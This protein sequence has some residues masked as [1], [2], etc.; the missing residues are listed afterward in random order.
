MGARLGAL[1]LL[2]GLLARP[3]SL[4]AQTLNIDDLVKQAAQCE[5]HHD[6]LEACRLYD[7]VLRR[8]RRRDDGR[9]RQA[10]QRC[11]RRYHIVHRHQDQMYRTALEHL[12]PSQALDM[13][14]HVLDTIARVY[15]D[16]VKSSPA[17]LFAQGLEELRLAFAEPVFTREYF[18]G[19]SQEKLDVFQKK[20]SAWRQRKIAHRSEARDQ[21]GAVGRTAQQMGFG[22]RPILLTVITLEFL[23]GAC[24][25]LDEYTFFLS[26]GHYREVQ[27]ALRGRLVSI[28]VDLEVN[29]AHLEIRRIYS[30][31]PAE[32]AGLMPHDRIL[33][34]DGKSTDD[35]TAERAAELLRGRSG[36][37]VKL[38]VAPSGGMDSEATLV[39]VKRGPVVVPSVEYGMLK[40]KDSL[41]IDLGEGMVGVFP[42]GKM[43]INY[44]QEST[45]QEV[46]DALTTLQM[47]GMKVLILDLRGNPG[48]LFKSAV[49]IAELF[50]PEGIIVIS[51]THLHFKDRKLSGTIRAEQ[52]DAWL[53]P[54][55]VLIDGETASAAE[56]LAG[57]LKDNGR[58]KLI[59]RTTFGK[60][61]IQ[62]IL[63][64]DKPHFERM[65]AGIR[66]TVAKLLSPS[67]QP[68]S[69]KG[70]Q[71]NHE[72]MQ[73]GDNILLEAQQFLRQELLRSLQAMSP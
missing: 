16:R 25:A 9:I 26:P 45:L 37:T 30:N 51:Q 50:L 2:L 49:E 42:I 32:K 20:L 66:I 54:M 4:S 3:A 70:I 46:K 62:C 73:E 53:M 59:G 35:L 29:G 48:G 12:T 39:E 28:G 64:L 19:V 15:T 61:S 38:E 67:W 58:A 34:I 14:A 55:V 33:R 71:P 40:E 56:V 44:F 13:Y 21:V 5:K 68:Y 60:G 11:L 72:S 17:A 69:G 43:T 7:E 18:P 24:N 57:A 41:L 47:A 8:D 10:Y 1:L 36:T 52:P 6:W 23:N 27:A 22:P 31:S 63:P 65:P